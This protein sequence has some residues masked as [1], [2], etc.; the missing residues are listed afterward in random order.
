MSVKNKLIVANW[1]MHKSYI[2]GLLLANAVF[3]GLEKFT[4]PV[5]V[6]LCPPFIHLQTVSSM[7]KDYL[8]LHSGAQNCHHIEEGAFT[9]E[10]SAKMLKSVGAEYVIIGHSERRIYQ[11]ESSE[12]IEGKVKLALSAGLK[13]IFCCGE[14]IE[15]REKNQHLE[16]VQRQLEQSLFDFNA[17]ELQNVIIAYEPIWAIGTGKVASPDQAQEMHAYIR[18]LIDEKYGSELS[19]NLTILYGGSCNANNSNDLFKQKDIDGALVGSAS[20]NATEFLQI[21]KN[22]ELSSHSFI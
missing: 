10:V 5:D 21:V 15:F 1:K 18:K 13:P 12:M 7:L 8:R 3:A 11:N 2:E 9:G 4:G 22:A 6:V 17:E 16:Y 20:L 19:S 14:P